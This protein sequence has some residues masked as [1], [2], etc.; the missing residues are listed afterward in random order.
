MAGGAVGHNFERGASSLQYVTM[1]P[2]FGVEFQPFSTFGHHLASYIV[3]FT[4]KSFALSPPCKI[5]AN[6][7]VRVLG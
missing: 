5:K 7:V 4:L 6:L 1:Y 3:N 2:L